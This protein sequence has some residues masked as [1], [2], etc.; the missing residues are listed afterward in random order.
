LLESL[1]RIGDRRRLAVLQRDPAWLGE[2]TS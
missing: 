2:A 1:P